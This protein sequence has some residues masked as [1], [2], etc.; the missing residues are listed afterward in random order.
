MDIG[1]HRFVSLKCSVCGF[2]YDVPLNC[3]DR[4]CP[5]CSRRR[6][7]VLIN[8]Y[9]EFF[10]HL[11]P[12]ACRFVTVTLKHDVSTDLESQHQILV[13]SVHKLI[14]YG[15]KHWG[16]QG[17]VFAY[18]ATNKGQGWHDHAHLIVQGGD[19]VPQEELSKV[20][21]S[22]TRDS[23]VVGIRF[24]LNAL[25]DLGYLLGYTLSVDGVWGDDARA[26]YNRVFKGRRLLQSW[27]TWF[28]RMA[29]KE[30]DGDAEFVCPK[31]GVET[32]LCDY[33]KWISNFS[34]GFYTEGARPLIV[35]SQSS[36]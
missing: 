8:R 9:R 21:Q 6:Y 1:N 23:Y 14:E 35:S 26:E 25:D 10:E 16:W 22:I 33:G 4:L 32:W 7:G 31:C 13:E 36:P 2:L 28:N 19:F 15:K 27:G 17:G 3:G 30:D 11:S 29:K 24:V 5:V 20:W 34:Q 18:Q 12:G